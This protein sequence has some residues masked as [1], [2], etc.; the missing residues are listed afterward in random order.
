M[1][2][3]PQLLFEDEYERNYSPAFQRYLSISNVVVVACAV[4]ADDDDVVVVVVVAVVGDLQSFWF[5]DL[6]LQFSEEFA[7]KSRE[8]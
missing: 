2:F 4:V 3:I 1:Q 7:S 6:H 5:R 8:L